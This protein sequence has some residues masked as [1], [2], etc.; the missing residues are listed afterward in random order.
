MILPAAR[1]NL[2]PWYVQSFMPAPRAQVPPPH[3]PAPPRAPPAPCT[4]PTR[5]A[6]AAPR[7]R[8]VPRQ[9]CS[10]VGD[11][12]GHVDGGGPVLLQA[13]QQAAEY[14]QGFRTRGGRL[15]RR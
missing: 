11:I 8:P 1:E 6:P 5:T 7:P 12:E 2:R 4:L 13:V 14:G 9:L 3:R 15:R 10:P